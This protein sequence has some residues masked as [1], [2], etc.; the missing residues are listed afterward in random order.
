MIDPP[1]A[2]LLALK[3]IGKSFLGVRVLDGVELDV[4]QGEVHASS[5]RTAPASRRS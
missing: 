2:P 4:A 5:A 1:P 3:G